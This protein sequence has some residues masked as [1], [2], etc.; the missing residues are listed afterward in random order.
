VSAT[1]D[2]SDKNVKYIDCRHIWF[3]SNIKCVQYQYVYGECGVLMGNFWERCDKS[4]IRDIFNHG[5]YLASAL[6][7]EGRYLKIFPIA[8]KLFA[9]TPLSSFSNNWGPAQAAL[10]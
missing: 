1:T 3:F 4:G 2:C 6:D 10:R 7:S 8:E 5:Y 9:A